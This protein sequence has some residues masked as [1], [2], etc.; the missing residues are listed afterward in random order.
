MSSPTQRSKQ[1]LTQEGYTVDIVEHFDTFS[2]KRKD[3]F[4]MFDLV[5]IKAGTTGVLGIQTTTGSNA[6]AR[7][8]KVMDNPIT[9]LWLSTGNSIEIHGWRKLAKRKENKLW[10]VRITEVSL[11]NG[12]LTSAVTPS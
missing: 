4:Y 7:L 9:K 8:H 6:S 3:L 1:Y 11:V 12:V 5:G 2:H 10:H